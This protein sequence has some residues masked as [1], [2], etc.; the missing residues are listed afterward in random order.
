MI[1]SIQLSVLGEKKIFTTS[2]S[3]LWDRFCTDTEPLWDLSSFEYGVLRK[4]M[5]P[6]S[7]HDKGYY[8]FCSYPQQPCGYSHFSVAS[9]SWLLM[10]FWKSLE[11]HD[12]IMQKD[13]YFRLTF[14]SSLW[15]RPHS[16]CHFSENFRMLMYTLE[17]H[18]TQTWVPGRSSITF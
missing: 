13:L 1:V 15:A 5:K 6:V 14:S 7:L 11:S 18:L 4:V 9:I 2:S 3:L 16:F 12:S 10:L 17:S 8:H